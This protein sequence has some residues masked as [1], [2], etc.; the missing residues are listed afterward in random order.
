VRTVPED[1]LA[2]VQ[3]REFSVQTPLGALYAKAW[4]QSAAKDASGRSGALQASGPDPIVLLHDS[5][6]S[7][8][9]WRDFPER[10]A[11]KT[12]RTVLAYDRLGYGRSGPRSGAI[13]FTYVQD[14]AEQ[15]VQMAQTCLNATRFVPL[16]H[17]IGGGMAIA[18]AARFPE[19]CSAV[20]SE[21][22]QAYVDARIVEGVRIES[23]ALRTTGLARL[24]R[25][26]GDQAEWVL[27]A[28]AGT[29]CDPEFGSW[30]LRADLMAIRCPALVIHGDEDEYASTRHPEFMQRLIS[31]RTRIGIVPSC[32]HIPHRQKPV[33][34]LALV[35]DFLSRDST[36]RD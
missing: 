34:V 3:V 25:Y 1:P 28:W 6:G 13:G 24:A 5:L 23:I 18:T 7:V 17:S 19:N 4:Y 33:E 10:L 11:R 27:D 36:D 15:V 21:S 20:I 14:E 9:L 22:A 2:P 30:S 16:G 31:A 35:A 32:G 12:G 8:G 29:W 26:H